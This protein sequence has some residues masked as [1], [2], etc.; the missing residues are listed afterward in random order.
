MSAGKSKVESKKDYKSRGFESPNEADSLTLLVHAARKGSG[1][2]LSMRGDTVTDPN[3]PDDDW[4][5]PGMR[6][7]VMI[8]ESNRSDWLNSDANDQMLR[9]T[10]DS[11][12][13]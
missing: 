6:N 10:Y 2:V 7:G 12:I 5:T 13:L 1:L 8:D 3:D 11:M 9:D 4:P